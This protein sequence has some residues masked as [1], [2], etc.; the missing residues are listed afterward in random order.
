[1]RWFELA[2]ELAREDRDERRSSESSWRLAEERFPESTAC[3]DRD[4]GPAWLADDADS[5][6]ILVSSSSLSVG[7]GTQRP[8]R[9]AMWLDTSKK[10]MFL[11]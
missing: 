8:F 9:W 6:V 1:V 4:G 7:C 3:W 5:A 10:W 11:G 2:A